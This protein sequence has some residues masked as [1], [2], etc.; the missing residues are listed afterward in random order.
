MKT[1][2]STAALAKLLNVNESTV[3][4]WSDAGDLTCVKTKGG[5]RLFTVATVM[6][7][8][9]RNKISSSTIAVDGLANEDLRAHVLAGNIHKLIPD[10]KNEMMSGNVQGVLRLL[11]I[12]F[13]A[14][15]KVLQLF[16]EV[17]FPTLVEIGKEWKNKA[18]TIDQEHLGSNALKEALAIFHSELHRKEPNGL[19]ALCACPE[20]ELH[21][22][23]IRCVG[24]YLETEGWNVLFLG[25]SSPTVSLVEAIK[26][27]KPN[28]VAL[29]A[30]TVQD[31][32]ALIRAINGMVYPASRRA[33][34]RLALGGLGITARLKGKVKADFLCDSIEAC[35][36]LADPNI[37][38][39][40]K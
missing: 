36:T 27:N 16:S 32:R 28:L 31:E 24:Y 30:I 4:R 10:L 17:I 11:R 19:K 23:A 9:Q 15:P 34:A 3:K 18:I 20:G 6:E 7:F 22:I 29:S 26:S 40:P 1:A 35:E 5:H 12:S 14:R 33:K 8:I 2:Y 25:Q 38:V 37:Y 39:I 13:V 21:E